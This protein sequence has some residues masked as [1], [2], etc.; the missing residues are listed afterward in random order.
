MLVELQ[1]SPTCWIY[2]DL[3][4]SVNRTVTLV[5]L[6]S[7]MLV[8]VVVIIV[9]WVYTF[10]IVKVQGRKILWTRRSI[11]WILLRDGTIYFLAIFILNLIIFVIGVWFNTLNYLSN[12]SLPLQLV[13]VS[14]L[15]INLREASEGDIYMGSHNT[16]AEIGGP[17]NATA[18]VSTVRFDHTATHTV[19]NTSSRVDSSIEEGSIDEGAS[20]LE[21]L[22]IHS[23]GAGRPP[24]MDV[25]EE[26][27]SS[28]CVESV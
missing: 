24:P 12:L 2:E 23:S 17:A 22:G 27:M 9:T 26:P 1:S 13:L 3:S 4:D 21:Q 16:S 10:H 28:E 6:I 19:E 20:E 11:S 5:V 18:E 14:R 15:V 7:N 25:Y 8:D